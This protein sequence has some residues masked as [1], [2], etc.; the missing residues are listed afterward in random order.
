MD[1][2]NTLGRIAKEKLIGEA[3]NKILPMEGDKP[4]I[5]LKAKI[6]GILA[7]IAAVATMAAE[8]LK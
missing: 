2:K 7:T 1:L 8:Y 4:K 5:G 3:T 6:A